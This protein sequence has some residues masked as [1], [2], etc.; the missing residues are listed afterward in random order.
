MMATS[1]QSR[2]KRRPVMSGPEKVI[3]PLE[4]RVSNV[5][6]LFVNSGGF[7]VPRFHYRQV[8]RIDVFLERRVDLIQRHRAD[9]LFEIQIPREWPIQLFMR[10]DESQQRTIG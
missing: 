1:I 9:L 5:P 3:W 2:S 6:C 10:R 4:R 8:S 7:V